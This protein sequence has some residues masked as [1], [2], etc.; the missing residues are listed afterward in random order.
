MKSLS[1]LV[2]AVILISILASISFVI[3]SVVMRAST[4]PLSPSSTSIPMGGMFLV[5]YTDVK[6]Q[7]PY[8]LSISLLNPSAKS[9][10][11]IQVPLKLDSLNDKTFDALFKG[12]ILS[13]HFDGSLIDSSGYGNYFISLTP[14]SFS[15]GRIVN[16]RMKCERLVEINGY[17]FTLMVVGS[18]ASPGKI[19]CYGKS[20]LCVE[21]TNNGVRVSISGKSRDVNRKIDD[22]REHFLLLEWDSVSGNY[23]LYIDS[24]EPVKTEFITRDAIYKNKGVEISIDGYIDEIRLYSRRL[25]GDEVKVL[26]AVWNKS[27]EPRLPRPCTFS[28]KDLH[29]YHDGK[30]VP[31]VLEKMN[32]K[33]AWIKLDEVSGAK[34]SIKEVKCL[35][36]RSDS[37]K[38]EVVKSDYSFKDSF[39]IVADFTLK[40]EDSRNLTLFSINMPNE[41][42]NIALRFSTKKN[43]IYVVVND[44]TKY[45]YYPLEE[46]KRYQVVFEFFNREGIV[47]LF[48][49]SKPV[50][51]FKF[52]SENLNLENTCILLGQEQNWYRKCKVFRSD[53]YA[54]SGII[55]S[56]LIY[57]RELDESEVANCFSGLCPRDYSL[58]YSSFKDTATVDAYQPSSVTI[59]LKY[60]NCGKKNKYKPTDVFLYYN[61][62]NTRETYE[63]VKV[64][65]KGEDREIESYSFAN[66]TLFVVSGGGGLKLS[67]LDYKNTFS[68]LRVLFK[69]NTTAGVLLCS[70][71]VLG[72][73]INLDSSINVRSSMFLSEVSSSG[74]WAFNNYYFTSRIYEKYYNNFFKE[75]YLESYDNYFLIGV[76]RSGVGSEYVMWYREFGIPKSNIVC[77]EKGIG[78][79]LLGDGAYIDYL[80]VGKSPEIY[81]AQT[82][83]LPS[84]RT[85]RKL[86]LL[87]RNGYGR[88]VDSVKV[89]VVYANGN[90]KEYEVEEHIRDRES[91]SIVVDISDETSP[92]KEVNVY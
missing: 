89:V 51:R 33:I 92:I 70:Y 83:N 22:G 85:E 74:A 47:K 56:F 5:D 18:F 12:L 58:N 13:L 46:G 53:R 42:R 79:I 78:V 67:A 38:K 72:G 27:F 59:E 82:L 55:Y 34:W 48:I 11:N 4:K 24:Y 35:D 71:P 73:V 19:F 62:F 28:L 91:K 10:S 77:G 39:T 52:P 44:T 29:A 8:K 7:Y 26:Y 23:S 57:D 54:F 60:G 90:V 16:P 61:D 20:S 49:N 14:P 64:K 50:L 63:K 81:F 43:R 80:L 87:V 2:S 1:P 76:D 21:A 3:G 40:K 45:L 37:T 65:V 69:K 15:G 9:Y 32:E 17:E 25:S 6:D 31:L 41:K 75:L 86:Y 84:T 36:M 30:E 88:D 66:S 68:I